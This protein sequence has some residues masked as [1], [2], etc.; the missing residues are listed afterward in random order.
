MRDTDWSYVEPD[1]PQSYT[2]SPV[3]TRLWIT[4]GLLVLGVLVAAVLVRRTL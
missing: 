3:T 1:D 4:A 2:T